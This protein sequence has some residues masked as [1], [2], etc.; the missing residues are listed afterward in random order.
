MRGEARLR[1]GGATTRLPVEIRVLGARIPEEDIPVID[2]NSYG[3][4]WIA[5]AYRKPGETSAEFFESDAFFELIHAHHRI[6]YE[7]RGT[8]HQLGYGHGGKVG[9]EFA[10]VLKGSGNNKRIS[11]WELFDRHYGPLHR[12][13]PLLRRIRP[14]VRQGRAG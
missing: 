4:S 5:S 11:S 14:P 2:H 1:A 13:Q 6:F 9:P 12:R 7:H 3:S 10:P 8:Y